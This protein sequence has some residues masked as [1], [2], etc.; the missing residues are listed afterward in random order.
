LGGHGNKPRGEGRRHQ[1]KAATEIKN[2]RDNQKSAGGGARQPGTCNLEM[3]SPMGKSG[4]ENSKNLNHKAGEGGLKKKNKSLPRGEKVSEHCGPN[5]WNLKTQAS[6]R[7][8]R[9]EHKGKKEKRERTTCPKP[10]DAGKTPKG[11]HGMPRF[12]AQKDKLRK[13]CETTEKDEGYQYENALKAFQK[14]RLRLTDRTGPKKNQR[15]KK[16]GRDL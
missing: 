15:V 16:K 9:F 1:K 3:L 12:D 11:K 2:T 5:N 4:P 7:Q 10:T 14:Q 6:T 8:V 13:I